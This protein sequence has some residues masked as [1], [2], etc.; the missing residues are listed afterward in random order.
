MNVPKQRQ[1]QRKIQIE[2]CNEIGNKRF[3]AVEMYTRET[4]YRKNT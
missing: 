2:M 1:Q 3:F 4:S